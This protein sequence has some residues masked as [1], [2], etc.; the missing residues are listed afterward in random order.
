MTIF[1]RNEEA[2]PPITLA[3]LTTGSTEQLFCRGCR[4]LSVSIKVAGTPN[5]VFKIEGSDVGGSDD[6]DWANLASD[7]SNT[8]ITSNVTQWFVFDGAI[9]TYIRITK[10]SGSNIA[11]V[12]IDFGQYG[13]A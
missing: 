2:N 12:I 6:N 7:D 5:D 10:I 1:A 13:G 3:A 8:T 11:T 9:P 4:D